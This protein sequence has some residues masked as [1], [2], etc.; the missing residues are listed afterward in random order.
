MSVHSTEVE[1]IKLFS[2]TY[3]AM[4]VAYFNELA[5]I[6]KEITEKDGLDSRIRT[7]CNNL[8]IDYDSY[9]LPKDIKQLLAN[10]AE[11]PQNIMIPNVDT[12][13]FCYFSIQGIMEQIKAKN[14]N[15]YL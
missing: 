1:V 12:D 14:W 4:C 2:N 8:S 13:N 15:H 3:L 10:Y 9:C 6:I 7:H 11:V 5:S